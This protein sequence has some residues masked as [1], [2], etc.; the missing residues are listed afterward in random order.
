MRIVEKHDDYDYVEVVPNGTEAVFEVRFGHPLVEVVFPEGRVALHHPHRCDHFNK[1]NYD[2]EVAESVV[3]AG[4]QVHED[5]DHENG[6]HQGKFED[7]QRTQ[8][9]YSGKHGL[10]K[11]ESDNVILILNLISTIYDS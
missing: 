3:G 2:S 8:P 7:H 11:D 4:G 9:E 6:N 1:E 10:L 5:A